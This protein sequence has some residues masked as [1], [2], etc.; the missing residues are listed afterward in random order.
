MPR[1]A[2]ASVLPSGS[3]LVTDAAA[4]EPGTSAERIRTPAGAFES[5]V[6][7]RL[8]SRPQVAVAPKVYC[9]KSNCKVYC[10]F[11]PACRN[12]LSTIGSERSI[13]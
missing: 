13:V 11:M 5:L 2:S 1:L 7:A 6:A 12:P 9:M 4:A 3:M 8:D 10:E